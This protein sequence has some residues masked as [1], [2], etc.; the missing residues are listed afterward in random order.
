MDV[1]TLSVSI[2]QVVFA[3][4]LTCVWA[5]SQS[6]QCL[7]PMALRMPP[8]DLLSQRNQIAGRQ[9][10]TVDTEGVVEGSCGRDCS[11]KG[12]EFLHRTTDRVTSPGAPIMR[13]TISSVASKWDCMCVSW[14]WPGQ[15]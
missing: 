13:F 9:S 12:A 14:V 8:R 3:P 11:D 1:K 5:I 15:G 7:P 6:V 10:T 2:Y 4:L